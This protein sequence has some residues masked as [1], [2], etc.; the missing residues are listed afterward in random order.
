MQIRVMQLMIAALTSFASFALHAQSN[1]ADL[2]AVHEALTGRWEGTVEGVNP[3][4]G[5]AFS[6]PDIFTFVAT[7][8]DRLD[9][10]FWTEFGLILYEHRD[11]GSYRARTYG[12][13]GAGFEEDLEVSVSQPIDQSGRGIWVVTGWGEMPDG[14]EIEI[15]EIFSISG[16]ELTMITEQRPRYSDDEDFRVIAEARYERARL[17]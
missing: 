7:G 4:T 9:A 10:A 8:S 13:D 2:S 11:R 14:T 15:R 1:D 5:E 12:P 17:Q 6:Q 3:V 16:A